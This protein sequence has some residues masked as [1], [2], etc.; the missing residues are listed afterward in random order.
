MAN[1]SLPWVRLHHSMLEWEWYGDRNVTAVFLHLILLGHTGVWRHQGAAMPPG[2]LI[3]SVDELAAT[4]SLARGTV[5]RA[6]E[7]L[8]RSGEITATRDPTSTSNRRKTLI[9]IVNWGEKQG[10]KSISVREMNAKAVDVEKLVETAKDDGG[11]EIGREIGREQY[12]IN[13]NKEN[14]DNREIDNR[15]QNAPENSLSNQNQ[16]DFCYPTTP[17][18]VIQAAEAQCIRLTEQDALI[19]ID[20][21]RSKGWMVGG[22][23]I[24]DWKAR[25]RLFAEARKQITHQN[26]GVQNDNA[27]T[28]RGGHVV[29]HD[30]D[31]LNDPL[32]KAYP[33]T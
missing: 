11:R 23:R 33:G 13:N 4:L 1:S 29:G 27:N 21:Y 20:N 10:K 30:G 18:E 17:E 32:V 9:T 15:A 28:I 16:N 22:S 31:F 19:F 24:T 5:S 7:V 26:K 6:L 2:T 25:I 12:L 14:L 8:K 3:T